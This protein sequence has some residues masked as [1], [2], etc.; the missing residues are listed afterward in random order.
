MLNAQSTAMEGPLT[1]RY[2][3]VGL[4]S[5]MYVVGLISEA[6]NTDWFS[7]PSAM[8][9]VPR[10]ARLTRFFNHSPVRRML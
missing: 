4:G 7:G 6:S 9:S 8:L 10:E 3:I 5:W 2:V 1:Y